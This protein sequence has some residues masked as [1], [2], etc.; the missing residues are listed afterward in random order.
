M[1][2]LLGYAA[3]MLA[4]TVAYFALPG[5][6]A[7][8]V[9]LLGASAAGAIVVR[10][11]RCRP[12]RTL[13]WLLLAAAA[14][15]FA[16][17]RLPLLVGARRPQ[18]P[19]W[20]A[21]TVV[22][23]P[24]YA[25]LAA[26]LVL[27]AR[28][29]SSGADRRSLVDAVTVAAG[30][31]MLVWLFRIVPT[32][33]DPALSGAQKL[34]SVSYPV[35]Q[36]FVLL[37]LG[38]LLAPG[39]VWDWPVRLITAGTVCAL[40]SG[41]VFGLLRLH[42]AYWEVADIG[43]IACLGLF[44][45]AA[46]HPAMREMTRHAARPYETSRA[47]LV[48]L[49]VAS[50]AA[51]LLLIL[52]GHNDPRDAVIAV[53]A[54]VLVL[55][56]QA[57][58]WGINVSQLRTLTWER[59]LTA[60]GPALASAASVEEVAAALRTTADTVSGPRSGHAAV[61]ATRIGGELRILMTSS[62]GRR[63]ALAATAPRWLLPV[64]PLLVAGSGGQRAS[65]L[66]ETVP[67]WLPS[68]L[69][70]LAGRT[71]GDRPTPLYVPAA[72]LESS[73]GNGNLGSGGDGVLLCPI[74]LSTDPPGEPPAGI[75]ALIGGQRNLEVRWPSVRILVSEAGLAMER[76]LL[77]QQRVKR[78]SEELFK[79]LIQDASDAI[80]IIDDDDTVRY[81]SPSASAIYGDV[82]IV[83]TQT[84][85]LAAATD[86]E[87]SRED[88]PDSGRNGF[89]EH[90]RVTRRD[91]RIV[92]VRV[93]RSDLRARPGVQGRVLTLRDVTEERRLQDELQQRA[94]EL[95]HRAFHDALTELPNR[96]LFADR[97]G[98]ALALARRTGTMTA[99]LFV[100]LDDFKDVNDTRGHAMGDELL[101]A[102][103][104]RLAT[105][106][107]ESDVAARIGGDEF[108]LLID[109]LRDPAEADAFA[110]RAM[111]AFSDP[112]VLSEGPVTMTAT[113]GVATSDGSDSVEEM[114]RHADLALYAAKAAGKRGWQR[115]SPALSSGMARR[116]EIRS[117]LEQAVSD[118]TFGL[119]YQPIVSLDTGH[120]AGF[121]SLIRWPRPDLGTLMPD[122]FIDVA[123][124][125]GLIVP[126]GAWVIQRALSDLAAGRA[127]GSRTADPFVSINVS[128]GQ[129]RSGNLV[130]TVRTALENAG[131]PP[132][133]LLLEL[134]ESVLL[135]HEEG[136]V[137]N[138]AEF[139]RLGVRL[140]IDDFGTG[141]SSLSY[142]RELP[143][144]VLKIDRSFVE[145]ITASQRRLALAK[146][147]VAIASTL[148]IAVIAEGI[149]TGEQ[150]ELL[151]EMGCEYGQGYLLARPM[152]WQDGQ[153]LLRANRPLTPPRAPARDQPPDARPADGAA[154]AAE[155]RTEQV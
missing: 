80:L 33:T 1:G 144:D 59:A 105:I 96:V 89:G 71:E 154:Q 143:I 7:A 70:L 109:N 104:R 44:G 11:A 90:W 81:A 100:D 150:Y 142:L 91:G 63:N 20:D 19:S 117:A 32:L 139:Q 122:Q 131:L 48:A 155:K 95:H 119:V 84:R 10:V 60:A 29:R 51:P 55:F 140:A 121:E 31:A 39:I 75:L 107:R 148:G 37:A 78:E 94:D 123:E 120:I 112:F 35:G 153:Q 102:F 132:S 115:Y 73:A 2:A 114:T 24:V 49:T 15:C 151:T 138:L 16:G 42:R 141:Y 38:R 46:V 50:L 116:L 36:I 134:T 53:S 56:A 30:L 27:F 21:S 137:A 82:P 8:F 28:A 12:A 128:A 101:T 152:S 69:P 26:A 86:T 40:V 118:S 67:R 57:R 64:V 68:V 136:I 13:P 43:M 125:T 45:A 34:V 87:W 145:G 58:L 25:L 14:L 93:R 135:R 54:A 76:I 130:T 98:H 65:R 61:F 92:R 52:E 3:W 74:F 22:G 85:R 47:R 111:A 108:A 23:L 146:G 99:V 124:D 4:L 66:A 113:V 147:I 88:V 133:L 18:L 17:S 6:S 129:F 103:A 62:A 72:E 127:S 83:G 79:E 126:L 110:E 97:A 41:V 5:L 149:E 77:T 9:C 106:A